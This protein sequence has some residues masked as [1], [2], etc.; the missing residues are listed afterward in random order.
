MESE[1]GN[2]AVDSPFADAK[3]TLSEFLSDDFG[4]GFGIQEAVANDLADEFLSATIF[5]LGASFGADQGFTPLI[6][7]KSPELKV[8][9]A[10][11]AEFGC[12][13]VNTFRAAFPVDEHDKLACDF[14]VIENGKG[15]EL[16]LNA[17]FEKIERNHRR[18]SLVKCH[19]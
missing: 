18:F 10:A 17:F 19:K 9:L 14:I 4:A 2:D 13:T 12:G 7:K 8:A 16:A 6:Q 11:E 15:T 1:L 3:V 5:G